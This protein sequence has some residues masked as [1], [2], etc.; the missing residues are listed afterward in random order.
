MVTKKLKNVKI[1]VNSYYVI[2]FK[3]KY[4]CNR[5]TKQCL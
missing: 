4:A 2:S 1:Y 5:Y 3:Y